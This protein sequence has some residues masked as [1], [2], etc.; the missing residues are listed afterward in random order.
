MIINNKGFIEDLGVFA[1][2]IQEG[3]IAVQRHPTED[4]SIYNYTKTAQFGGKWDEAVRI[5]RGLIVRDDGKVLARPFPKFFNLEE[6]MN[7]EL[8][9]IPN[10]PFRIQEKIDGSLGIMYWIGDTPYLATRGS[11]TSEQAIR[12]TKILQSKIRNLEWF[13]NEEYTFLF[14]I[15]Y[16]ANRIVVDYGS[17]EDVICLS[18]IE[19][20]TGNNAL[21]IFENVAVN[22]FKTAKFLGSGIKNSPN[23]SDIK[24]SYGDPTKDE[25]F[26]LLFENG[27]RVKVKFDE[28][29]RLH[30]LVTGITARRIWDMLRHGESLEDLKQRVPEEFL[31]WVNTTEANLKSDFNSIRRTVMADYLMVVNWVEFEIGDGTG[32]LDRTSREY[33]KVFAKFAKK[34]K[35]AD[36][37]FSLLDGKP[38]EENVWKLI[39]PE[40]EK[41]FREDET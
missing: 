20:K 41:P 29:V 10:L 34:D 35:Y 28:Y 15:I 6:H 14:E 16:P 24:E 19:N 23:V 31:D 33:R 3:L 17:L 11:F 38:Y 27:F 39:K 2:Y 26:V 25:G 12:G 7:P 5:A 9:N 32:R 40:A 8:G 4:F 13:K 21:D 36:M 18:V 37:L 1:P 30:R 22:G